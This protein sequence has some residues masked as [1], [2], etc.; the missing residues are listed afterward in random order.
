[1][2][3]SMENKNNSEIKETLILTKTVF[4]TLLN[5]LIEHFKNTHNL[6]TDYRETQLFGFG[7]Y[8]PN[9]ANLKNDL[10]LVVKGYINGKY[11]YNKNREA[12]TGKPY[13]KISREY[14]YVFFNYLGYKDVHEFINQDFITSIQKSKQLETLQ[15]D[16]NIEDYY[17]VCYYF[18]EDKKMNKGQVIIYNQWKNIEMKYIYRDEFGKIGTYTYFGN[19]TSSEGF[20]WFDTKFYTGN[21]KNDGAKFIFFVGK[22]APYE[23]E[24][25]LGTYSGFDKYDNT[26]AGKMILKKIGTRDQMEV[27]VSNK[28][29]DPILSLELSKKR[30]VI[31]SVIR[32]N[33]LN[34]SK[35][36]PYAQVLYDI[37]KK[38]SVKF[39]HK[40][41][42]HEINLNIEK[43]HLNIKSLNPSL[44]IKNDQINLVSNGQI[45]NL[46]FSINGLF[47]ILK[48]SLYIK[49][50]DLLTK[51]KKIGKFTAVDV[52]N[53]IISGDVEFKIIE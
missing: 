12:T 13:I 42:T 30:F 25:L 2:W 28:Q 46:D 35:K 41:D 3:N 36:S 47:Y 45:I 15:Q 1:M 18:G 26:I 48:A 21:K 50:Y 43:I 37:A 29:F 9:K 51:D 27:E 38:Y 33:P 34:F 31:E 10:E 8:D 24:F 49:S 22:S 20:V 14:K 17:Y 19:I 44:I 16:N 39:Y 53:K 5:K 6:I 52:N 40:E 7:N 4:K 23:R 32:K 11:L